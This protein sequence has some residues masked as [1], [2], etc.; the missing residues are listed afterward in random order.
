MGNPL[1]TKERGDGREEAAFTSLRGTSELKLTLRWLCIQAQY[2]GGRM[3]P[4][5]RDVFREG[6]T[7]IHDR[8][9]LPACAAINIDGRFCRSNL[10]SRSKVN[11]SS[12]AITGITV[13]QSERN[14][15][16]FEYH[17]HEFRRAW[18]IFVNW[19]RYPNSRSK[20]ARTRL[21]LASTADSDRSYNLIERSSSDERANT[22]TADWF[23]RS[24]AT[25]RAAFSAI[26]KMC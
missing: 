1:P 21:L 14:D 24:G 4:L 8:F 18:Y 11:T 25:A 12:R 7:P 22:G 20:S 19:H 6:P 23:V 3:F 5:S 9:R 16:G 26:K 15:A 17:P 2:E 10:I 13:A